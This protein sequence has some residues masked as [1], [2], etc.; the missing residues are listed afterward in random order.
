MQEFRTIVKPLTGHKGLVNHS[1]PVVML[2]SC[3]SENIGAKLQENL[4]D[5]IVNPMGTLYNPASM[6]VAMFDLLYE[7]QYTPDELFEH[8]G[9]WHSWSHHSRFS[10]PDRDK[11]VEQMNQSATEA[12]RMLAEAS[13]LIVTFGTSYIFRL[14][15]GRNVVANCHKMPPA[16]FDREF[17]SSSMTTGLWKKILRELSARFPELKVIFTVSPIRHLADG[18]HGNILSKSALLA[19][20]DKLVNENPGQALY[21]PSY[22]IMLDDLRDYRF[23]APDM[24][25][26]SPVA[27]DYIFDNFCESFMTA[28]DITLNKECRNL[29]GRL[30]HR[31]I[32]PQSE[33]AKRFSAET[34]AMAGR[35]ASINPTIQAAIDRLSK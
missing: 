27:V 29:T 4:F 33:S 35:L 28:E 10:G 31:P 5:C 19:A 34:D 11:V 6:A 15:E 25:H 1:R 18:A 2:G 26:P 21:F 32:N 24:V 17:L 22:E 20:I 9:L 7:R 13:V 8:D 3:F 14:K 23:Y 16:M 12:R 30:Q